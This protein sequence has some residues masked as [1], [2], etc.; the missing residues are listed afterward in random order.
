[1]DNQLT[2]DL[3][4]IKQHDPLFSK[5]DWFPGHLH[6]LCIRI[7]LADA[8]TFPTFPGVWPLAWKN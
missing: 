2:N 6:S 4:S 1:M 3:V 5:Y 7:I 8:L